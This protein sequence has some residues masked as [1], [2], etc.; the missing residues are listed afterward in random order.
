MFRNQYDS[1]VT[2]YSP[3]GRLHQ[4]E[5]AMES[6]KL[7]SVITGVR[8]NTHVVLAAIKRSSGPLCSYHEKIFDV[9]SH[10][11]IAL[12][13][14]AADGR[15]LCRY[16]RREAMDHQYVYNSE[17][18]IERLVLGL[19]DKSQQRTQIEGSRPYGV[20]LIVGGHDRTGPRLF[21]TC[22][23]GNCYEYYACALGQRAQSAMSFF[24]RN[25]EKIAESTEAELVR[26]AFD[27]LRTTLSEDGDLTPASI[28]VA[29]A[30]ADGFKKLTDDEVLAFF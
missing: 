17:V 12:A 24:D 9:D 18:P 1:D 7:G 2:T 27:A 21:Q 22:P 13:G 15:G 4:V 11:G 16:L 23:S 29:I 30:G 5:Y 19:A 3:Q 25:K 10:C 26:L 20:S 8:S 28:S 14:L 6:Q